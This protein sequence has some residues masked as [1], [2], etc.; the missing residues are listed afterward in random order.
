MIKAKTRTISIASGKGGAGKTSVA[1]CL[2]WALAKKGRKVC[3]VDAD[4]GLSNVDVLLGLSPQC[5]LE[6]VILGD[7]PIDRAI[8]KVLPGLDV[9][10]GGAGAAA[11]ADLGRERRVAFLA[12]INSLDH[13]DFLILDNSP[14][15]HRQVIAFCLAAREQIIMINPEPTSV[16]D[17]YALLKVLKQNGLNRPPYILLNRVLQGFDHAQ[18]MERFAAVCKKHLQA[19]ILPLGAV[20]DDPFF[21][22][23]AAQSALPV[24]L[25]P[26]SPG[27][28]ALIQVADLLAKRTELK[29]LYSDSEDFW[30]ASLANLFQGMRLPGVD[31]SEPAAGKQMLP[32][33]VQDL[34]RQLERILAGLED[35]G[36]RSLA[37]GLS[38][39]P[40]GDP[41]MAERLALAGDRLMRMAKS[42]RTQAQPVSTR[43]VGVF[44]P[45]PSLQV[46]LL[47][48]LREKGCQPMAISGFK[49]NQGGLDLLLCSVSKPDRPA[50]QSLQALS[51]VPCIWLSEYTR[52]VPGWAR[53]LN[54][55]EVVE[56]PFSLEKIYNALDKA[57]SALESSK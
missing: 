7:L 30:N 38:D 15:I 31:R 21:R 5:T 19:S 47:E 49:G 28:I 2:A 14:G 20:P 3:L 32:F 29:I 50:L 18:F 41:A 11:L 24:A 22:Q 54:V 17:G 48:L 16:T 55:I 8:T 10:S 6:D 53:G 39:T 42:L 56:K 43:S 34:V 13:Y 4:L 36:S 1:A 51:E 23:A 35:L 33:P 37:G 45:D 40:G 26:Q 12:K 9:I 46:L 27:S 25:R 57:F 44:C 52:E